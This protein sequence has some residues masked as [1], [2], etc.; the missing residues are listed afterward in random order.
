MYY[1]TEKDRAAAVEKTVAEYRNAAGLFPAIR[2]VF[3]Q[4]D[5]KVFNCRLEEALQKETG[6]RIRAEKRNNSTLDIYYYGNTYS[7]CC[8]WITLAQIK[9]DDMKDRKRI[10]AALL[11]ESARK[12]REEHLQDAAALES[13][14]GKMDDVKKQIEYF[15]G[16]ANR[17]ANALPY[18]LRDI[19]RIKY[20]YS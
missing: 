7:G 6:T 1:Y 11:I 17:I 3:E 16:Q 9:L 15:I 8:T 5:G 2:R 4:F 18:E 19:Y 20:I 13:Y 12:R 10:P 14:T